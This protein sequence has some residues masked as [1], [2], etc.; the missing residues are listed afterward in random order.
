[1]RDA[2]LARFVAITLP[3]VAGF[4]Y[5]EPARARWTLPIESLSQ[6]GLSRKLR[7]AV[8]PAFCEQVRPRFIESMRMSWAG[9]KS[10]LCRCEEI[11]E[12]LTRGFKAWAFNNRHISFYNVSWECSAAEIAAESCV[13]AD[14]FLS[15]SAPRAEAE[16]DE[17]AVTT[18]Q[19]SSQPP[20]DTSEDAKLIEGDH[21]ITKANIRFILNDDSCYYLDDS[22]CRSVTQK[23]DFDVKSLMLGIY[24]VGH[25][26][27][28]SMLAYRVFRFGH[29]WRTTG[30]ESAH[31]LL[32]KFLSRQWTTWVIGFVI[33]FPNVYYFGLLL[34]CLD[35][36]SFEALAVHQIGI[37]LGLAPLTNDAATWGVRTA[38]DASRAVEG[39]VLMDDRSC[40]IADLKPGVAGSLLEL[41]DWSEGCSG[42]DPWTCSERDFSVM[43]RPSPYHNRACLSQ[44]DLDALNFLYP[45][46]SGANSL[47]ICIRSDRNIVWINFVCMGCVP[48]V[49]VALLA[50]VGL[51][52]AR[53]RQRQRMTKAKLMEHCLVLFGAKAKDI[54]DRTD[55]VKKAQRVA[56]KDRAMSL[57]GRLQLPDIHHLRSAGATGHSAELDISRFASRT[58]R[59]SVYAGVTSVFTAASRRASAVSR[60]ASIA[61]RR[62]STAVSGASRRASSMLSPRASP[63]YSGEDSLAST[64]EES[65]GESTL[66]E[67][68]LTSQASTFDASGSPRH[69]SCS[70]PPPDLPPPPSLAGIEENITSTAI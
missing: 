29:S 9:G 50:F 63:R 66:V 12:T 52:L 56:K 18:I 27:G 21:T 22:F 57:V 70:V 47:P 53:K 30:K 3:C 23:A 55:E 19:T 31:K 5:T 44:D 24:V 39:R 43:L 14:I 58:R 45:S 46:C 36:V 4:A 1:M 35:C 6:Q 40:V 25:V 16:Q 62:A 26:L 20:R 33:I 69:G 7:F 32:L 59:S 17:T 54:F 34:P 41:T 8:D 51:L 13:A 48:L 68:P 65:I 28:L 10:M 37:A 64:V 67:L 38:V 11:E 61:S 15:A 49:A 2:A 42:D 60:H